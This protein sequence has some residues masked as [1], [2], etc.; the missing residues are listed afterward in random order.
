VFLTSLPSELDEDALIPILSK[1]G[2]LKAVKIA[3]DRI[4][5]Q[6]KGYG[7]CEYTTESEVNNCILLLNNQFVGGRQ[8]QVKRGADGKSTVQ[9][10]QIDTITVP[11]LHIYSDPR[12]TGV[13]PETGCRATHEDELRCAIDEYGSRG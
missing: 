8:I 12:T 1:Y 10:H 2:N 5:N 3:R 4:S 7:F 11:I 9:P 13:G 6:S